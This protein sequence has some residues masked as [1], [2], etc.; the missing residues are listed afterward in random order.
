[1]GKVLFVAIVYG[2]WRKSCDHQRIK[3]TVVKFQRG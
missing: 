2:E 3:D 1:M